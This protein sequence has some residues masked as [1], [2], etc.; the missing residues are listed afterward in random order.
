M[1]SCVRSFVLVLTI[2]LTTSCIQRASGPMD[3]AGE[4]IYHFPSGEME[5]LVL[6]TDMTYLH[7]FY[8]SVSDY[9][10]N[11]LPLYGFTKKWS[12]KNGLLTL[13]DWMLFYD[14][15]SGAVSKS[16]MPPDKCV[17]MSGQWV[18]PTHDSDAVI[19]FGEDIGYNFL[20][21]KSRN[22]VPDL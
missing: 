12:C 14:F 18:E 10:K 9:K 17:S 3:M 11:S 8:S 13:D 4:Y 20:R 15:S 1:I 19:L 2:I 6:R 7:E 5:V 16:R 22:D 21:V